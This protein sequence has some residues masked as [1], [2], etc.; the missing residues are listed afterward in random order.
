[1]HIIGEL[2]GISSI[3][4]KVEVDGNYSILY[5]NNYYDPVLFVDIS[6]KENPVLASIGLNYYE[7]KDAKTLAALTLA[8]PLIFHD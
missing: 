6:G 7:I 8:R 4:Y 5:A 3:S 2:G 1:M